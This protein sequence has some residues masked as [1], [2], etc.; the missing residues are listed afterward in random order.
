[1]AVCDILGRKLGPG[2]S[3]VNPAARSLAPMWRYAILFWLMA[4]PLAAQGGPGAQAYLERVKSAVSQDRYNQLRHQPERMAR[5]ATELT[6]SYGAGDG[7]TAADIDI[8]I[9][10]RRAQARARALRD[11]LAADLN[12]DGRLGWLEAEAVAMSL[13]GRERARLFT[14][15]GIAD[16]DD[17]GTVD[18]GELRH[19]A[20]ARA[21]KAFSEREAAVWRGLMH[22]D[23]DA[24]GLLDLEEVGAA[25]SYI[26]A[27]DDPVVRPSGQAL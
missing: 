20:D 27:D 15:F 7:L 21:F 23:L 18:W 22:L 2:Q 24:D 13:S 25:L 9:D 6:F 12:G 8:A 17:D 3:F 4:A 16:E 5:L 1:M 10:H 26:L 11:L 14:R 19:Y